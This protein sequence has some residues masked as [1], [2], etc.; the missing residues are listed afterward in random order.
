MTIDTSAWSGEGEFTAVLIETLKSL[1]GID[2]I[3]VEDAPAS[4]AEQGYNFLSNEIYV[5]F[6]PRS[7]TTRSRAWGV[8]PVRRTVREPGMSM[9]EL[10]AAL[11]AVTAVGEADYA[12]EGMLQYLRTDRIIPPYQTRGVKL[13]ELVRIYQ[14]SPDGLRTLPNG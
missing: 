5:R 10:A 2:L 12:D 8:L 4:R 7:R 1:A 6:N 3:K 13:V 9:A 11:A 14:V